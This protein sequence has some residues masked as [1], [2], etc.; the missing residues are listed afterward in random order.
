VISECNVCDY[1]G[2]VDRGNAHA[3]MAGSSVS[4][5]Q[6]EELTLANVRDMGP[7]KL[8]KLQKAELL[9]V[10]NSFMAH[11]GCLESDL[12][13]NK[14][15]I[16]DKTSKLRTELKEV[17]EAIFLVNNATGANAYG[18][19][20]VG[21]TQVYWDTGD[22]SVIGWDAIHELA[23][24]QNGTPETFNV[25]VVNAVVNA[26]SVEEDNTSSKAK[27]A[28][29]A[30]RVK[31]AKSTALW[32]LLPYTPLTQEAKDKPRKV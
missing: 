27:S 26:T 12:E 2:S 31:L 4:T 9:E 19:V 29:L 1:T 13:K 20:P 7:A 32:C 21:L 18:D 25:G 22:R 28:K 14:S 10:V 15:P 16:D 23:A 6:P 8:Q 11:I 5:N 3:A 24:E 17:K 30:K